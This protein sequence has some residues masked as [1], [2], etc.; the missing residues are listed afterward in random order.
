M[1]K[2]GKKDEGLKR[3][4]RGG[5]EKLRGCGRGERGLRGCGGRGKEG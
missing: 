2:V 4:G 1:G 3:S 5:E